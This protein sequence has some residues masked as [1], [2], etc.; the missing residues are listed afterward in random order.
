[1][2]RIAA[3]LLLPAAATAGD[4]VITTTELQLEAPAV[5]AWADHVA[6]TDGGTVRIRHLPDGRE[7]AVTVLP[8]EAPRHRADLDLLGFAHGRLVG[9]GRLRAEAVDPG[10][11]TGTVG[12]GLGAAASW[13]FTITPDTG[14]I[15]VPA[16]IG[17][18]GWW[19]DRLVGDRVAW[20]DGPRLVLDGIVAAG[21]R[22][23][24]PLPGTAQAET[25]PR[26]TG[27]GIAIVL[28]D[29]LWTDGRWLATAGTALA[30]RCDYGFWGPLGE[31]WAAWG[32]DTLSAVDA[33][34]R[35]RWRRGYAA[36]VAASD[37]DGVIL[38][39]RAAVAALDRDGRLRWVADLTGP[40]SADDDRIC[41]LAVID[42]RIV[43][44]WERRVAVLDR[45]DG[46][47][48]LLRSLDRDLE[49]QQYQ[50]TSRIHRLA[51]HG[52]TLVLG[53]E[54]RIDVLTFDPAAPP[55]RP[56][57]D[58]VVGLARLGAGVDADLARTL[59][60]Q[61]LPDPDRDRLFA[62]APDDAA[63]LL[64]ARWRAAA[65]AAAR[66][67]VVALAAM[68]DDRAIIAFAA[69]SGTAADLA[70]AAAARI[71]ALRP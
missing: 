35:L 7:H 28:N 62:L 48:R 50:I 6:W 67:R 59:A 5:A 32:D 56:G 2:I 15:E 70:R 11:A 31:G 18:G 49:R 1:M 30:G 36:E 60:P 19:C 71:N 33:A 46:A 3:M 55:L 24:I 23:I 26:L 17:D 12:G 25:R 27:S 57:L 42:G 9:V 68:A 64:L 37:Q 61:P 20:S 16:D 39:T 21:D 40:G 66:D 10:S 14:A 51:L 47:V 29:G 53:Y 65:D 52:G 22:R 44:A 69:A 13:I 38:A 45:A 34:G 58:P 63:A 54:R 8:P 4:A 43:L 41:N